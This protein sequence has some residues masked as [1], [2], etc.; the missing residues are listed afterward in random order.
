[1]TS[2]FRALLPALFALLLAC[3]GSGGG[4]NPGASGGPSAP[5][6][7]FGTALLAQVAR[8]GV[9]GCWG[10][11]APDGGRYALM[12][13]AKGVLVADLRDPAAPRVVDELDGPTD[14]PSPGIFWREMRVHGHYAYVC[15]EETN[16][17]GGVM[18][19]DLAGLPGSVRFVRSFT[20]RDGQLNAHTLDIDPA[21]GLLYLQR[22]TNLPPPGA[23][24]PAGLR[25]DEEPFGA[26]GN[27]SIEIWDLN[28]DPEN[29]AFV[30]TFNQNRFVHDMTARNGRCY[31]AEGYDSAYSIWDVRDP[32]HPALVVRWS[33]PAGQFAH[34]IWPS[35][36]G[37]FVATTVEVPKDIPARLW[38]L[39]GA[40][41]PTARGS[42][43]LGDGT[44]H[45]V[46]IEGN[47][48]YLSHYAAGLLVADLSD[49]DRPAL[50]ANRDT[51]PFTGPNYQGCWGVYK[52][53][54]QP[55]MLGSDIER[56][57]FVVSITAL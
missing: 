37:S 12:G 33:L 32:R 49:L 11:T 14:T 21:T 16:F 28:G 52:F 30:T 25:H 48:A 13:T 47:R 27:G 45:N 50:I 3:G 19:I 4:G 9:A 56:G 7:N 38:S 55:L 15:A 2:V 54:G 44:P 5:T 41:P 46:Q 36:D 18:I 31:V 42:I 40:N 39:N 1:M 57:L 24:R 10:Y 35:P 26:P 17:R 22:Y 20:P 29:P 23:A 34:N 8:D 53:P 51:S 43:K 6:S